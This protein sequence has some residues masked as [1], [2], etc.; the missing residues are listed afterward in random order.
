MRFL[1]FMPLILISFKAFAIGAGDY[2]R[3]GKEK[4]FTFPL[5]SKVT[6]ITLIKDLTGASAL[7]AFKIPKA[8]LDKLCAYMNS[9]NG[10]H[11][12]DLEEMQK[13]TIKGVARI[14]KDDEAEIRK[15]LEVTQGIKLPKMGPDGKKKIDELYA[16]YIKHGTRSE[17]PHTFPHWCEAAIKTRTGPYIENAANF[18]D[19][20]PLLLLVGMSSEGFSIK[21]E[22]AQDWRLD[23]VEEYAKVQFHT[24]DQK[25]AGIEQRH[26]E[27]FLKGSMNLTLAQNE[28]IKRKKHELST[29][30]LTPEEITREH[31]AIEEYYKQGAGF[32]KLR[33]RFA[34]Y[35]KKEKRDPFIG[36]L[37]QKGMKSSGSQLIESSYYG[38]SWLDD[39]SDTFGIEYEKLVA[40]N[41]FPVDFTA[42]PMEELQKIKNEYA[43]A[44]KNL[45][46]AQ[47]Q[48]QS[49]DKIRELKVA[50]E[51]ARDKKFAVMMSSTEAPDLIFEPKEVV[52]ENIKGR[53]EKNPFGGPSQSYKEGPSLKLVGSTSLQAERGDPG[54]TYYKSPEVQA[55][56]NAALWKSSLLKF[57][58]ATKDL[59]IAHKFT[60]EENVF[61]AKVFYNGGQ[62]T[63]SGAYA[64]L[65]S[66]AEKNVLNTSY[67]KQQPRDA[68]GKLIGSEVIYTNARQ[69]ADSYQ[70]AKATGCPAR[71]PESSGVVR[72]KRSE[73]IAEIR[74]QKNS[75][76]S[77]DRTKT[78]EQ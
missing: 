51:K 31:K 4:T 78:S 62:G 23:K 72:K 14:I 3:E 55:Y 65:K 58:K 30:S 61:W 5:M 34:S 12:L 47:N 17:L 8:T 59:A 36:T 16:S 20:D 10:C 28:E 9:E 11:Q 6:S 69:V 15:D 56:A 25:E 48:K 49:E 32:E 29:F 40:N 21:K 46:L 45:E 26:Y 74:D 70:F 35:A 57:E 54:A 18:A 67:L 76:R 60:P 43:E 71:W 50:V 64:M 37:T 33:L 63:Q 73:F 75:V 68:N 66:F 39:G 42:M 77:Q 2:C 22:E 13:C 38:N 7:D 1:N 52:N 44:V 19:L 53:F 41:L 27:G 24:E